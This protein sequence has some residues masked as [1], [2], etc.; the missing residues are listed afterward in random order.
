[1][2]LPMLSSVLGKN[3]SFA[4]LNNALGWYTIHEVKVAIKEKQFLL[5]GFLTSNVC[6]EQYS[7]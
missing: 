1:M 3:V 4:S 5:M 6:I 2:D 7:F